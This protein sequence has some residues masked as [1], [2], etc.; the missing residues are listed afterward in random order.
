MHEQ[1]DNFNKK[2]LKSTEQ[3]VELKNTTS[4]EKF[5][6]R[7]SYH[8]D[9]VEE[10]ISELENRAVEYF[11]SKEQKKRIKKSEDCLTNVTPKANQL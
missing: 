1:N 5:N 9:Q 10:R 11:Q 7:V 2:I 3:I 6:R 8:V 4:T